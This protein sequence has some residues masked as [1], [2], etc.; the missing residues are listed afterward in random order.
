MKLAGSSI[1]TLQALGIAGY[2]LNILFL[3]GMMRG[4]VAGRK[5]SGAI[6]IPPLVICLLLLMSITEVCRYVTSDSVPSEFEKFAEKLSAPLCIG[7]EFVMT[8]VWGVLWLRQ[9]LNIIGRLTPQSLEDGLNSMPDGVAFVSSKGVPLLVNSTMQRLFRESMGSPYFDIRDFE[10]SMQNQTLI[11]GCSADI[12]GKGYYLHLS[13]GSVWDIQ[14]SLMM[15][16]GRKVWELLAYDVT[17]RYRKSLELEERNVHLEEVNRSIRNYTREMN[18]IIREEE[19]L[20]AKIR[21]HDDVGRALLALKSY[22]IRGG[23]REDLIEMWQFTAG[24]LSGENTPDD[25]AD[26]IGALK[27]A[28]DAV[29]VKLILNGDIPRKLRKLIAI[30]IHE[31]LTNTV[32]HADGSEL[33]VDITDEDGIVTVVFTNDGKPPESEI[34]ESGGLKSLRST[35]EQFRGEMEIA[36]EP[37]FML[38]IRVSG[39]E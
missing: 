37:R 28:A 21:I 32:K 3:A 23:D 18:A 2:F 4:R 26:P 25:S 11:V 20:A 7:I 6:F 16:D 19:V 5:R 1:L 35:V 30:A 12:H 39:K 27:E 10:Y 31:C 33:T 15:I 13:D 34:S 22:L 17:E 14:K 38:T 9:E 36:S 29:G 8:I 24:L